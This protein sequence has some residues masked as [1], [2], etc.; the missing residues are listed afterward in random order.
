MVGY[1]TLSF[2]DKEGVVK[3]HTLYF[4]MQSVEEFSSRLSRY[5]TDNPFKLAVD[6]VYAGVANF[7]TKNDFPPIP[8]T[9]IYNFMEEFFDQDEE[10]F[11]K[12]VSEAQNAFWESK[13]GVQYREKINELKKKVEMEI[14]EMEKKVQNQQKST[15]TNLEHM[16]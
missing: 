4:G 2:K 16:E 5:V 11:N 10:E 12:Q 1:N 3:E 14:L 15:T 9:E 6:L 8:Y 13:Y 7:R